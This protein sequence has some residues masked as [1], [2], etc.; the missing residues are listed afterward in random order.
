MKSVEDE[1]AGHVI[2]VLDALDECEE[3]SMKMLID[4]IVAFYSHRSQQSSSVVLKFLVT[5]R[6]YSRFRSAFERLQGFNEYAHVDGDECS[7]EISKEINL[8]IDNRVPPLIINLATEDRDRIL[9]RL[10]RMKHQ[11]YLW[12]HLTLNVMD[13]ERG[14]YSK[15]SKIETLLSGLPVDVSGAYERILL[16]SDDPEYARTLLEIIVAARR[17]LTLAEANVA[18][19][20]ATQDKKPRD[21]EGLENKMWPKES[22]RS[23]VQDMCGLFVSVHDGKLSLI[24]QTARGFLLQAVTDD[25]SSI[26]S[27]DQ[28][29]S[30][31]FTMQC[32]H[33][34][35]CSS[36]VHY[37]T[38]NDFAKQTARSKPR[39]H[40]ASASSGARSF[41][42]YAAKYWALHY[43]EAPPQRAE[44]LQRRAV[45]LCK[46]DYLDGHSLLIC[47]QAMNRIPYVGKISAWSPV[48]IAS[49]VGLAD[50]V[51]CLL[52][53]ATMVDHRAGPFGTAIRAAIETD[54]TEV[55][56]VL[57]PFNTNARF[58][59]DPR[60]QLSSL[61][62]PHAGISLSTETILQNSAKIGVS[63]DLSYAVSRES[64]PAIIRI[65]LEH[66][67]D[68]NCQD[69]NGETPLLKV[70][71][72]RVNLQKWLRC[73]QRAK[74]YPNKA[75]RAQILLEFGA[76]P[77]MRNKGKLTP[78][79]KALDL[80]CH[81]IVVSL[82]LQAGA[83]VNV[84]LRVGESIMLYA[85]R[86]LKIAKET[87]CSDREEQA[88][89]IVELLRDAG[90]EEFIEE[91]FDEEQA[92]TKAEASDVEEDS[93]Q[94]DA[95]H[96]LHVSDSYE[97][98]VG[99]VLRFYQ[100]LPFS[101]RS[102]D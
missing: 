70:I 43:K 11:T 28:K 9:S 73:C 35:L 64:S 44:T 93:L 71:S 6:P 40:Y 102:S 16:Q 45:A 41:V 79:Q 98:E 77:N 57:C 14:K 46:L 92:S 78:L 58:E 29:W 20:V 56:R 59:L 19:T 12:L 61:Q 1:N 25:S 54:H 99:R 81:P 68:P 8:V 101:N 27:E 17:P 50:V 49:A 31:C 15:A 48:G 38:L 39:S 26:A 84:T 63:D 100:D 65:L 87:G 13:R 74:S 94:E 55:L 90:A 85:E 69:D 42:D 83:N 97:L 96:L 33:E 7:I 36:C 4:K 86:K 66:G 82:L 88:A 3:Q 37:L 76:D 91:V 10:K 30:S 67:V 22:F 52:A 5:S 21:L 24:H 60:P 53:G 62:V 72:S 18:L 51:Q 34:V 75:E 95:V 2:C 89:E 47:V 23:I 80:G 32:A